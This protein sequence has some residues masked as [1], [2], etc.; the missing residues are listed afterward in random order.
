MIKKPTIIITTL[1]RTGTKFFH[2][3]FEEII[4]DTTSLHEP[5]YLNFGQ[6]RGARKR[7]RQA[8]RQIQ[9]S[10]ASNLII[11]KSLGKWSLIE[12]SD[13]RV[14]RE[15]GYAEAVQQVLNQRREFIQS[16]SGSVYVES[17]SAYY[18]LI[19]VLKDVYEQHRIVYI[20]RDGRDWVR[21]KMNWGKMYDKGRIRSIFSHT[22]P[23]AL[24]IES[25]SYRAK[26]GTMSIFEKRCWAWVRLNE[27]ALGTIQENPSARVFRFED[28]FQS[29][30][31]YQHLED[32]VQFVTTFPHAE[33]IATGSL[34]GWL[35]RQIHQ[36][37]ARFPPWEEWSTE[38]KQQFRTICG[39]LMRK[40]D[41]EFD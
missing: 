24:E 11:R 34:E 31:R 25:D 22:W 4:P 41:Y 6:Y 23:T 21:S 33:P 17:S 5:D 28:V 37:V 39:P 15:L 3:L 19:D 7:I 30:D 10:G 27:Y 20:I 35:D 26:W 18:G 38:H 36:S 32:L 1:G 29:E 14:R 2:E 13:A 12:L 8:I 16:Q 9:E 40:L